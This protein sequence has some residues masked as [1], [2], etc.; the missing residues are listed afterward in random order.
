MKKRVVAMRPVEMPMASL[1]QSMFIWVVF[2]VKFKF[3][4]CRVL[5]ASC[6]FLL[7]LSLT[8]LFLFVFGLIY[9]YRV[10][11][12]IF[13]LIKFWLAIN[14]SLQ[15]FLTNNYEKRIVSSSRW[16]YHGMVLQLYIY[17]R[18]ARYLGNVFIKRRS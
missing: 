8:R 1:H 17:C 13:M 11:C 16:R 14:Q 7:I 4:S 2:S 9:L 12:G 5:S 6:L 15:L 3:Y 10:V 18:I